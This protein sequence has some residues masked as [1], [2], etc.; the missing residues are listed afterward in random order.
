MQTYVIEMYICR[1]KS[2]PVLNWF[3]SYLHNFVTKIVSVNGKDGN[4]SG[5]GNCPNSNHNCFNSGA[6]AVCVTGN[7]PAGNTINGC[8]VGTDVSKACNSGTSCG[9]CS[10]LNIFL[11]QIFYFIG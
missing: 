11:D 5:Q 9:D 6:C 10:K 1:S 7:L 2:Q 4:G 8:K 3:N